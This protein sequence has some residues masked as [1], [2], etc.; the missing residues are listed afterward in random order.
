M[1]TKSIKGLDRNKNWTV[2]IN[3]KLMVVNEAP[4]RKIYIDNVLLA[5]YMSGDNF[6]QALALVT[7]VKNNIVGIYDLAEAF[8]INHQTLY[9]YINSYNADGLEG[10]RP[11]KNCRGKISNDL[12]KICHN[13]ILM[14]HC[15]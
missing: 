8:G 4:F 11:K 14:R 2:T 15:K 9:N 1:A 13:I 5:E 12:I 7:I 10:L 6:N 3:S